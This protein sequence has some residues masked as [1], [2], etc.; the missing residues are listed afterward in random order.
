MTNDDIMPA[1]K[2]AAATYNL[3]GSFNVNF[4]GSGDS[5]SDFDNVVVTCKHC[6]IERNSFQLIYEPGEPSI[7]NMSRHM[8]GCPCSKSTL[9][10]AEFEQ[11]ALDVTAFNAHTSNSPVR[12]S[13]KNLWEKEDLLFQIIDLDARADFNNEGSCGE[14]HIYFG[15]LSIE[16][17]VS[18][19]EQVCN[20][21]GANTYDD[22]YFTGVKA[23]EVSKEPK[24]DV[25]ALGDF[26]TWLKP[27]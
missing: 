17:E 15:S 4:S 18:Q 1:I 20:D 11:Q 7:S 6:D 19:Y 27:S 5:F 10:A 13:T 2:N 14:I 3:I 25:D 22:S 23:S 21:L 8:S 12:F 26:K 24:V 16:I 9:L